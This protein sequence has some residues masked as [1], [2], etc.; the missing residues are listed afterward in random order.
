MWMR[1]TTISIG[2]RFWDIQGASAKSMAR[3]AAAT[4]I[5]DEI[6]HLSKDTGR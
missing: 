2:H 1:F 3:S 6:K 5:G 4:V